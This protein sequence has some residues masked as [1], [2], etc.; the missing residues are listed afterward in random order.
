MIILVLVLLIL[1][2]VYAGMILYFR[3][4]WSNTST[5]IPHSSNTNISI[6][7]IIPA[8][9]EADNIRACLS[10]VV[11]QSYPKALYE[12]ILINDFSEDD[13]AKIA[14]E[15][16]GVTVLELKDFITDRINSYKK[17]AIEIGIQHARGTLIV[18]TDADCIVK[19]NWLATI[20]EFHQQTQADFIAMP[21]YIPPAKHSFIEIFQSLDFMTLQ[22]IT[23]AAVN[24]RM[25]NMCNGANLAYTKAAFDN[26]GGFA[27]IDA[28]ASGDDMLL[29]H[30]IYN[31][32][33]TGVRFL[34]SQ[35]VIVTTN[36]VT[37]I[38]DFFNQRIRW[39]SKA[40]K[41]DDKR[42]FFVLLLVYLFN[43]LMLLTPLLGFITGNVTLIFFWIMLMIGKTFFELIFLYPVATFFNATKELQYFPLMQPFHLLY[44]VIAGWL[45]KF[46]SYQWKGRAVK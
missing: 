27:G 43:V 33:S 2:F 15:F 23:A 16:P 37:T 40:D 26:V 31:N 35:E 39:A 22:G 14:M 32:N 25:M 18:T 36:P 28:I 38:K 21:V 44:T 34:K 3:V 24:Q 17:K 42:I 30:K 9:N 8:R 1:F 20:A 6:S 10:S 41:Y 19:E 11:N 12:I 4:G 45:G 13:T 46:G 29:M 5:F 7:V